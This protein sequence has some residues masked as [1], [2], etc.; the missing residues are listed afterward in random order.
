MMYKITW[1]K[2]LQYTILYN[3]KLDWL[4]REKSWK[5][6]VVDAYIGVTFV[7]M[8]ILAS[9]FGEMFIFP[10]FLV[11]YVGSVI[12][13]IRQIKDTP[14]DIESE[15]MSAFR[16]IGFFIFIFMFATAILVVLG[17]LI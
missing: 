6:D 8:L 14:V 12:G 11:V 5:L 1:C 17:R 13:Y 9:I 2:K 10:L 15:F 16:C 7:C 3:K 4:K